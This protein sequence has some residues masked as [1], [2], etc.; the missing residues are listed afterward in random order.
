MKYKKFI[1]TDIIYN[2]SKKE[3][4]DE[5]WFMCS[6]DVIKTPHGEMTIKKYENY[7]KDLGE[8]IENFSHTEYN[9]QGELVTKQIPLKKKTILSGYTFELSGNSEFNNKK[10]TVLSALFFHQLTKIS[11]LE[12]QYSGNIYCQMDLTLKPCHS[13]L[14]SKTEIISIIG[15][16]EYD[17]YGNP[18]MFESDEN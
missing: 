18:A 3:R 12:D 14:Y 6:N 8:S 13:I 7:K 2:K 9:N 10:Y 15:R 4:C 17:Q 16:Y 5:V 11:G 1:V